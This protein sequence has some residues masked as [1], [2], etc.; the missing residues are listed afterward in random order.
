MPDTLTWLQRLIPS[1][2]AALHF[3]RQAYRLGRILLRDIDEGGLDLRATSLVYTS[4]L[5]MA[6]LLAV[7]FSVLKAFG[8]HNQMQ[9]FLLRMLE[10]LGDQAPEIADKIIGFVNNLE[11]GV[12]GFTGFALLFWTVLSLLQ[13]IEDSCNQVWRVKRARGMRRRFSD[14]LSVLLVGPV[15]VF[16]A[17]GLMASMASHRVVQSIIALEPF[18]MLYLLL[19]KLLPTLFIVAAFTFLYLFLPNTRVSF[20]A[21]LA[22]GITAGLGWRVAGWLFGT[23]VAGSTQYAAIYSSFAILIVFMIWLYVNWLILLVGADIAFYVQHPRAL[24]AERREVDRGAGLFRRVGLLV[25]YLL[26]ERFHRGE[27]PWTLSQLVVRLDLPGQMVEG[28]LDHLARKGLVLAVDPEED[29]WMPARDPSVLKVAEVLA[30]LDSEPEDGYRHACPA[31]AEPAVDGV[32]TRLTEAVRGAV[33][34]MSL[35]DLVESG[36]GSLGA[37]ERAPTEAGAR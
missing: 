37:A 30:V 5:S 15:L 27:P 29:A 11:V 14:Y 35:N 20:K 1:N 31:L 33:G 25:M 21:A 18:G 4:L 17:L 24:R 10:P 36:E 12:L 8:A 3:A 22:G 23:F 34:E 9:P 13:K 28:V 19:V 16:S 6:P 7:S 32:L 2:S 26:A